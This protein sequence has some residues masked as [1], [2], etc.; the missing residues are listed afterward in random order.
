LPL[1]QFATKA[2][3]LR[4]MRLRAESC[5]PNQ[6]APGRAV[7]R[8]LWG[9]TSDLLD[10]TAVRRQLA[11]H[12]FKLAPQRRRAQVAR[13][14][15]AELVDLYHAPFMDASPAR[16]LPAVRAARRRAGAAAAAARA[17][18]AAAATAALEAAE[19]DY[20]V[21]ALECGAQQRDEWR[22][23]WRRAH[24]RTIPL[25]SARLCL[26]AALS[27]A[28]LRGLQG[29]QGT[30]P[31]CEAGRGGVLQQCGAGRLLWR[32]RR[33]RGRGGRESRPFWM[34]SM[35]GGDWQLKMLVHALMEC[36]AV[37]PALQWLACLWQRTGGGPAPPLSP[38]V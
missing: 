5:M 19:N 7:A 34:G 2:A 22:A 37:R 25:A 13:L 38:K 26:D 20:C 3:Y 28:V 14:S 24:S 33:L 21:D 16:G 9:A 6:Y 1:V 8:L 15:K 17:A 32:R 23:V 10:H 35:H 30:Q 27:G 31:V 11:I 4:H 29:V 12:R 18:A 36:P